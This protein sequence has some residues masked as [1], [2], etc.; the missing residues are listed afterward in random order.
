MQFDLADL[1]LMAA[2]AETDSLTR[3]A[4]RAFT[5]VSAASIRIKNLEERIGAKLLYRS[6]QGV[7]LSPPGQA[8][9]HHARLVLSQL[10][11]LNN[12]LQ[13]YACG[14]KGHLRVFASAT[15][16]TE[17]LPRLLSRYL[18]GHPDVNIDLKE[19]LSSDIVRAVSDGQADIGVVSGT[20]RIEG[21]EFRPYREDWLVLLVPDGH[22]LAE[23]DSISFGDALEFDHIGL[24][25]GSAIHTFLEQ[26]ARESNRVVPLRIQVGNFEAASRMIEARVGIGV[27]PASAASRYC[28]QARVRVVALKDEWARRDLR[29]CFRS[30]DDLPGFAKDLVALLE[31]DAAER[32]SPIRAAA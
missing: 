13:E 12:D 18:A 31:R 14:V 26:R 17:F 20:A 4:E 11:H 28:Q 16:V 25:E 27:M 32:T 2:I 7:K 22:A 30:F 1:R 19:K 10:Q 29:I 6:S 5:S 3:G 23:C 21:L 15:A 8:F 24:Q 9:A